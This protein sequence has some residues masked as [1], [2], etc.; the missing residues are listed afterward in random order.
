MFR[1][2]SWQADKRAC[3]LPESGPSWSFRAARSLNWMVLMKSRHARI[4]VPD[5]SPS[6]AIAHQVAEEIAHVLDQI[7]QVDK[8]VERIPA[9]DV[10]D[11]V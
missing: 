1:K 7:L 4:R 10:S 6:A 3:T 2:V 9:Q 8:G 11:R 5:R